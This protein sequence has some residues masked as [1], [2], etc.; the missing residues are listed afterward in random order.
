MDK[1]INMNDITQK[2]T[3][4]LI[5]ELISTSMKCWHAQETVMRETDSDKVAAAAKLAQQTNNRR[6]LLIRAIDE[7]LGDG[8]ITQ[9]LKSY[10]KD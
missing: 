1:K 5:D 2:S 10:N 7:R 3:A 9:F 4:T 6:N 8:D